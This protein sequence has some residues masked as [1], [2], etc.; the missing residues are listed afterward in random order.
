LKRLTISGMAVIFTFLAAMVPI[1]PPTA[2]PVKIH[3]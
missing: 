1:T 2:S 3:P